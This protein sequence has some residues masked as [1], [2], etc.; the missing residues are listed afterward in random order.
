MP[1]VI[2]S[3]QS[4][5]GNVRANN[6]DNLYCGGATLT[7]ENRELPFTISGEAEVPCIFAV[8]DGMGGQEDGEFA[9]FSAVNALTELEYELKSYTPVK[10]DE[11]VQKYV[12]KVNAYLCDVMSEK[13]VRIGSTLALVIITP[14]SVMPY[15]IGDSRIYQCTN[16]KL[17]QIS[18]DHTLTMQK[19]KMGILTEEQARTD[20]DRHKLTRYLGIFEDEMI[21]EAEQHLALARSE[22]Q[23]LLLCSDGLTDMLPDARIEEIMR[24][25]PTTAEAADH[26]L[27]E[28]LD[29]GGKDNT[30]IIVID[31]PP[32]EPHMEQEQRKKSILTSV[33]LAVTELP[34]YIKRGRSEKK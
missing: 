4:H 5:T 11:H 32:T 28:A 13:S 14:D 6:E 19:V 3:S 22:H 7:P 30:T 9:S 10:T 29:N 17:R 24:D 2:Y 20:R 26:L 33:K 8:C 31:I 23:R 21:I 16:G 34:K 12:T 27:K 1:T 18:E 15:N 25:M